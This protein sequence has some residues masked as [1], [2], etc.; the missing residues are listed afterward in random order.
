MFEYTSTCL[1]AS[2]RNRIQAHKRHSEVT[3]ILAL[4]RVFQQGR[5]LQSESTPPHLSQR[6]QAVGGTAGVRDDAHLGLVL[7]LV[8]THHKHGGVGGRG[9]DDHTLGA[10]LKDTWREGSGGG[11]ENTTG[12]PTVIRGFVGSVT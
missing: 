5:C 11:E 12:S 7:L 8:H 2:V 10:S 3:R 4:D 9:G 1:H 6:C